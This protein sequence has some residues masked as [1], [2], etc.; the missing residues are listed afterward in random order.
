M[1]E[2]AVPIVAEPLTSVGAPAARYAAFVLGVMVIVYAFNFMDRY[3]F[4]IMM[5]AIKRDLRLSDTQLGIITGFAFST[6]YSLAGLAVAYWADRGNRRSLIAVALAAW[7]GLTMLCA[8]AGSFLQ[9]VVARMSVGLAESAC[10]PPALSLLS[11]YFR[12][13]QR[14]R[15]FGIYSTGLSLG[16]CMGFVIG[17]WVGQHFG[18][19][20]AL[21]AGGVP[22][23]LLAVFVRLTVREP[24]RGRTDTR[25]VDSER[26][27]G[28]Q[29]A[30]YMLRRPSFVAWMLGS[31]LYTFAGTTIDS[32]APLFLIRVHGLAT[33]QV[34]LQ[35]GVLGAGGGVLG[36]V[37]AGWIADRLSPQDLRRNLWV[38]TFGIALVAP[39][40][41]LFL[42]ADVRAVWPL[43]A[44]GQFFNCFYMAPT[45]AITHALVPARL[46]AVASA[47]L[48]LGYN[49]IG[50]AGCSLVIGFFSDRWAPTLHTDS[51]RYAMAVTQI[52]AVLGIGCTLYSIARIPRDFPQHFAR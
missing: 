2:P 3:I 33:A 42:F 15:A 35:T 41:L 26:Y 7:S 14:G 38:S 50:T 36:S 45:L 39:L 32:W 12:V 21:F 20:A 17:G 22:G 24:E 27:T 25:S 11:D 13:P 52:A 37:I 23:L 47:V 34:G 31:A 9:L 6:V 44:L 16:L 29:A 46:R 43:Y 5:E 8:Y 19:R 51:V 48:L 49:V 10:S 40:T 30:A 18:W 4:I 1:S 28:R